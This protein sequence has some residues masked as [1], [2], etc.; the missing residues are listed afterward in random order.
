M[1][2]NSR[3]LRE[4][5]VVMLL[6]GLGALPA[7][8]AVDARPAAPV[9]PAAMSLPNRGPAVAT[10]RPAAP[11]SVEH[12]VVISVDGLRPDVLLLANTPRIHA[13]ARSGC[14]S[15]WARTTLIGI[16]LPSHTSM[17]T[18]YT[19]DHHGI[20]WNDDSRDWMIF[21]RVP[22]LFEVSKRA[23]LSTAMATG[24]TKFAILAKPG[25]VDWMSI[26]SSKD[27]DVARQAAR[28]LREDRPNLLFVH[29]PGA[30]VAGHTK[31]WGTPDQIAAV[32]NIDKQ[33]GIV[34]DTITRQGLSDSTVVLLSADH[35]GA[36][37]THGG[38]D[39][40]SRSIPWI[41]SGPGIRHNFDLTRDR[42]LTINTEDTFATISYLLNLPI[43]GHIDGKPVLDILDDSGDLMH[44][45]APSKPSL[46]IVPTLP[47]LKSPRQH[48]VQVSATAG[49][50]AA[51]DSSAARQ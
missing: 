2:M 49:T 45:I 37:G 51:P 30:D 48:T 44:P 7:L 13:L 12:A 19:P 31:G 24:K 25:T 18:G 17:L 28:I 36:G 33:V 41:I 21:P 35:G 8:A 29:F 6:A 9:A 39:P 42:G 5:A 14:Y 20:T 34:L 40:R 47:V 11:S 38:D 15:F 27:A 1:G 50:G 32:E 22:T 3:R 43:D 4:F 10:T 23:G 26:K 46:P 16:T